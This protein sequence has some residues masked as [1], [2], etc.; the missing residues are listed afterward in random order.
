MLNKW[1]AQLIITQLRI[2][3]PNKTKGGTN[4]INKDSKTNPEKDMKKSQ[5]TNNHN[6]TMNKKPENKSDEKVKK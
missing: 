4:T 3:Q 6:E 5:S 2:A 1:Q